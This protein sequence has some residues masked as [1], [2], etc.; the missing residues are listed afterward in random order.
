M[1]LY[2]KL[3]DLAH[4]LGDYYGSWGYREGITGDLNFALDIVKN[5]TIDEIEE[6]K[7]ILIKQ[8]ADS[9]E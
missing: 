2:E 8:I 9:R 3:H 4:M 7:N 5:Y 1:G 6:A